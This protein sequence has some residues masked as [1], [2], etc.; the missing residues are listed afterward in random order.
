MSKS[1]WKYKKNFPLIF[2]VFSIILLISLGIWQLSRMSQKQEF[3]HSLKNNLDNLPTKFDS[4]ADNMILTSKVVVNGHFIS[5]HNIHLYGKRSGIS[6]KNGYY[7]LS[8]FQ[9]DDDKII[10]V[11]R[12][13]FDY[14]DKKQMQNIDNAEHQ[15]ITGIA[16]MAEKHRLFLPDN[17]FKNNVWFTLDLKQIAKTLDMNIE[18]YYLLS[19]DQQDLPPNLEPISS[20]NLLAIRN[21]HLQYAITW[22][23]LA[24]A[25][26]IIYV[27][28]TR[29]PDK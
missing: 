24:L 1:T 28:Y 12:G 26:A 11:A 8:P 20:K 2:S 19:F 18:D 22:F 21:D 16:L 9:T 3:L 23:A 27:V 6:N 25:V 10:I 29:N 15:S 14:I 7:L 4:L 5:G 13:W 17:D